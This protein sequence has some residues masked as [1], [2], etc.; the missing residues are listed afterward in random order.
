M[1]LSVVCRIANCQCFCWPLLA[2]NLFPHVGILNHLKVNV[3]YELKREKE[4]N[5]L[6][7]MWTHDTG[8]IFLIQECLFFKKR[9]LNVFNFHMW[10]KYN[11]RS[12]TDI[13]SVH[14]VWNKSL[15][16]IIMSALRNHKDWEQRKAA[17]AMLSQLSNTG[18][19]QRLQSSLIKVP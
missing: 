19:N 16:V 14:Q 9:N 11:Y 10:E 8:H 1:N 6:F 2:L 7:L 3:S 13:M 12:D 18:R 17:I 5:I 15:E 4:E